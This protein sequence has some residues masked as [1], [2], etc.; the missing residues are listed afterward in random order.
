MNDGGHMDN[1]GGMAPPPPTPMNA[2]GAGMH[3]HMM[4]HH[5]TFFWGNNAEILFSGWPGT[6]TGMYALAL[7]FVFL[8][9]FLAELLSQWTFI[10]QDVASVAVG[11]IQTVAHAVRVSLAYLVMLALMSFNGGVFI[12]AVA[13][14]TLGFL[15][16]GSGLFIR[17]KTEVPLPPY[18]NLRTTH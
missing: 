18:E 13:G 3:P 1:M 6:R 16:F 7:I 10:K 14:H 4:M 11:L 8:L 5:M 2:S 17:R 12:A 15:V 9:A